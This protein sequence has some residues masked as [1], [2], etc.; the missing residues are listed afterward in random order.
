[1]SVAVQLP[2]QTG[3]AEGPLGRGAYSLSDVSRFAE[4][5][6][7]T[8]RAWFKGGAGSSGFEP[9]LRSE[10]AHVDGDFAVSFLCMIEALVVGRFRKAGVSMPKVREA[11]AR[12]REDIGTTHPFAHSEL[13]TDGRNVIRRAAGK[14]KSSVLADVVVGQTLF[15]EL[16]E[17]L[18]RVDYADDTKLASKWRIFD[19]VSLDPGVGYGK[20]VLAG[21]GIHTWVIARQYL[22][23]DRDAQLVA[24]LYDV[25]QRQ[26]KQAVEFEQ[27]YGRLAA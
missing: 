7:S 8:A 20:P 9:V 12:L 4:I 18:E 22:A 26:V 6:S 27:S 1:M 14:I 23:N 17:R 15:P 2:S 3:E 16:H 13:Y 5:P 19:G 21:T 25:A 10:Y 11:Y 24:S